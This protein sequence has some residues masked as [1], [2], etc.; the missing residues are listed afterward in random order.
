[1]TYNEGT[2]DRVLR[3]G[4]GLLLV[5][6]AFLGPRAWWLGIVGVVLLVTGLIGHCPLYRVLHIRTRRA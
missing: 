4:V 2:L 3:F 6:L 5:A 1:M